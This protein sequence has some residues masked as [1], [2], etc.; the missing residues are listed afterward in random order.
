MGHPKFRQ[1]MDKFIFYLKNN[2]E[3][4]IKNMKD[5]DLKNL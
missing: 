2:D 1:A 3:E 5:F 4:S